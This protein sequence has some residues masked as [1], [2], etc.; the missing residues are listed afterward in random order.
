[1]QS[2]VDFF[3]R[4]GE[5]HMFL[6]EDGDLEVHATL[7]KDNEEEALGISVTPSNKLIQDRAVTNSVRQ[8]AEKCE[9]DYNS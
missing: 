8:A 4:G 5:V 2:S 6:N 1:M 3:L 9:V 7:E